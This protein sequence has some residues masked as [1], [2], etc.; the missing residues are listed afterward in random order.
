M[1]QK[2][3]KSSLDCKEIQPVYPKGNQFWIFIGSTDAK[4][5][6]PILWPP[7]A[8][9]Q[10]I[11][12]DPDAGKDWRQEEKGMT[13]DEMVG[14]HHWLNGHEFEQSPGDGDGQGSL[15]SCSPW[16]CR[17]RH[18]W[19]TEQQ[20]SSCIWLFL[21]IV[22]F[23]PLLPLPELSSSAPV[24]LFAPPESLEPLLLPVLPV[25][26]ALMLGQHNGPAL[27]PCPGLP[28]SQV[29]LP[30]GGA[31]SVVAVSAAH[32]VWGF[33]GT[34]AAGRGTGLVGTSMAG[35]GQFS[36]QSQRKAMTKNVQT[37]AQLH[38]STRWERNAQ[39]SPSQALT[40]HEPW[41]SRCSSW[42]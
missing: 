38:L 31:A 21:R 32:R 22:T 35:K 28:G 24:P 33:K 5:E 34:G 15:A 30:W 37:M 23:H 29:L 14:W 2:T 9:S 4:A 8:K 26:L 1:L 39:N 16:D 11:G 41:T 36:L 10:H 18:Y 27:P 6:A 19:E 40:V 13:E 25:S 12:E 17:V 20:Q 42:I 7:D 3:L